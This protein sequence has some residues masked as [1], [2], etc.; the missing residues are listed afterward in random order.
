[1]KANETVVAGRRQEFLSV[2]I[3]ESMVRR[4]FDEMGDGG[5]GSVGRTRSS[6]RARR[7]SGNIEGFVAN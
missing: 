5:V 7:E 1:M 4:V 3:I 6:G 2:D